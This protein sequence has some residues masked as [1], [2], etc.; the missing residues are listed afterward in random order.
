MSASGRRFVTTRWTLVMAAGRAPS[1]AGRDALAEL[2]QLYWPPLYAYARRRG[3]SVEEAQDLTQAFFTRFLE[4]HDVEDADPARGRFRSFLLK[5]FQH[6][7][8]NQHERAHAGKRGG[9]VHFVPLE[10]EAAEARYAAEPSD[11]LTPERIYERQWAVAVIDRARA[12]LRADLSAAGKQPLFDALHDLLMGDK[13]DRSFADIGRT[14]AMSEGAVRVTVH[15]LRRR[16]R[17]L[18][19]AEILIT[20][21]DDKDVDEELD[22]LIEVLAAD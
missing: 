1:A 5:A 8:F 10:I 13:P 14:L 3:H 12:H 4:K 7:L 2:C 21:A 19:R 11:T 6:F 15:R 17:D 20:V 16:L 9:G 18:I 22:Y